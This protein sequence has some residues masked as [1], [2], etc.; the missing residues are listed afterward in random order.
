MFDNCL[1]AHVYE[2]IMKRAN[3]PRISLKEDVY[4]L[5]NTRKEEYG[6]SDKTNSE[7][8]RILLNN[9]HAI[10]STWE[11]SQVIES[12]ESDATVPYEDDIRG[13][14][15]VAAVPHE[16]SEVSLPTE[17]IASPENSIV[18]QVERDEAFEP[19]PKK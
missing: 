7:F 11:E 1:L 17:A 5:W 18:F 2:C 13:G 8:A 14:E 9:L 12:S 16:A 4:A 15:E 6:H 19:S 3:D 10:E